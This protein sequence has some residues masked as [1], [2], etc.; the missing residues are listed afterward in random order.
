MAKNIKMKQKLNLKDE[1]D[2][3]NNFQNTSQQYDLKSVSPLS[4]RD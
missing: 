4:Y 3:Q 1:T 2:L